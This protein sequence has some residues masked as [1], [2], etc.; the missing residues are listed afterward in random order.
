[1]KV[2]L[3]ACIP[4][5]LVNIFADSDIE[6]TSVYELEWQLLQNGELLKR[7]EEQQ[8]DIFVTIDRG[9]PYQ[10]NISRIS[11]AL[12]IVLVPNNTVEAVA[13]RLAEVRSLI[14]SAP[15]QQVTWL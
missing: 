13:Q 8:F 4:E 2:L 9:I 14:I 5:R 1:M 12:V 11:F 6:A 3:D 7:M 10:Q 15:K